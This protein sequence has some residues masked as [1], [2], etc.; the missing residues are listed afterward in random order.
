[1]SFAPAAAGK[2]MEILSPRDKQIKKSKNSR[3][4]KI[5]HFTASRSSYSVGARLE[6][7]GNLVKDALRILNL[8]DNENDAEL[9]GAMLS[10]R[11]PQCQLV[12]VANREEY[13]AALEQG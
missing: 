5:E 6:M 2:R 10:A 1:M 9:N 4:P 12:R 7:K 8:E 11:W 3:L 13:V